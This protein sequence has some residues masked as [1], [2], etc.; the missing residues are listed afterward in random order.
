MTRPARGAAVRG[1]DYQAAYAWLWMMRALG[2]RHQVGAVAV[3]QHDAGPFDDVVLTRL[4][5]ARDRCIQVKASVTHESVIEESWLTTAADRS[6]SPLQ[7]MYRLWL[8][9]ADELEHSRPELV[10]LA[11]R[12]VDP[13]HAVLALADR[14]DGTLP[15]PRLA[16]AGPRS[17]I[18]KQLAAWQDHL[19][20]DRE[21]LLAFLADLRVE[22]GGSEQELRHAA[23]AEMVANGLQG[24]DTAVAAGI[25]AVR[26]MLKTGRRALA[27]PDIAALVSHLGLLAVAGRL[28]LAVHAIDRRPGPVPPTVTVDLVDRY[29]GD[30]PEE[31]RQLREPQ[32]WPDVA[33][34]L[35]RAADRLAVYPLRRVHVTGSMRLP[36]WYAVGAALPDVR[37]WTLSVDQRD[38]CWSTD[39]APAGLEVVEQARQDLDPDGTDLAVAIALSYDPTPDVLEHLPTL[40][41]GIAQLLV[42]GGSAGIGTHAVPDA[43]AA[44][45]WTAGA[46]SLLLRQSPRPGRLHLFLACPA[47]IALLLGHRRNLL[48]PTVLYEHLLPGYAPTLQVG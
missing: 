20:V 11:N 42:L 45:A 48:P 25:D 2:Q 23:A 10:L 30:R 3:E 44:A 32:Q 6:A 27:V 24:G 36:L 8:L 22:P 33:D 29:A 21:K 19:D 47:G 16:A 7:R 1:D 15:M 43:E 18:G 9:T 5:H 35:A 4:P 26:D 14:H 39:A 41:D 34:E 31:R 38:Q 46:R 13:D 28:T 17:D 40:G 37:G 12:T